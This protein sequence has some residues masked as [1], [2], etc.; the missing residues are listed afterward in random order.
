[1]E[2]CLQ[3]DAMQLFIS[4]LDPSIIELK[5]N[6]IVVKATEGPVS[7]QWVE[8]L[9]RFCIDGKIVTNKGEPV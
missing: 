7:W 8:W 4:I 2:M 6:E 9:Q 3:P 5:A 1:M